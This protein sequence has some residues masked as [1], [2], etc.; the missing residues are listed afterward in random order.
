MDLSPY[1][2]LNS[3]KAVDSLLQGVREGIITYSSRKN[4]EVSVMLQIKKVKL[5][6]YFKENITDLP[7]KVARKKPQKALKTNF[8]IDGS[9][10]GSKEKKKVASGK[11]KVVGKIKFLL[12]N[13]MV[14][15]KRIQEVAE[16][17]DIK[18]AFFL[19]FLTQRMPDGEMIKADDLFTD[20]HWQLS[21]GFL[22]NS[23]NLKMRKEQ[24]EVPLPNKKKYSNKFKS[25]YGKEGNYSKL[26]YIGTKS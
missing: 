25:S 13:D 3:Q 15:N 17:T 23:Y 22:I 2:P 1:L 7:E 14:L 21:S 20:L 5:Q 18:L 4:F 16:L 6:H 12:G 24:Q 11:S 9:F 19:K 8:I 26:I 10:A